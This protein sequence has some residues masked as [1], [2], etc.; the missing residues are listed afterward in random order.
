MRSHSVA[1][2]MH[3][4]QQLMLAAQSASP[5]GH[6]QKTEQS[7]FSAKKDVEGVESIALRATILPNSRLSLMMI[8]L[9]FMLTHLDAIITPIN[10][11]RDQCPTNGHSPSYNFLVRRKS[12][13]R[14][15]LLVAI[16]ML[17][18]YPVF[19]IESLALSSSSSSGMRAGIP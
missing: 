7:E 6:M 15:E 17:P 14:I 12:S 2:F 19:E 13:R 5:S 16:H 9:C 11:R 4:L 3:H 18:T 8:C 1:K 10:A